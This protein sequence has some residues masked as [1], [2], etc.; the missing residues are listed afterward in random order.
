MLR[1][2]WKT[3]WSEYRRFIFSKSFVILIFSIIFIMEEIVA[4]IKSLSL[5]TGVPAGKTEAFLLIMSH[6][7]YAMLLPLVFIVILSNFPDSCS[8]RIYIMIRSDRVSWLLGELLYACLSGL[9]CML[10][11]LLTSIL[12]MGKA[13]Q[14]MNQWSDFMTVFFQ[15]FPEEYT[16]NSAFFIQASTVAQGTPL[17]VLLQGL[18]LMLGN[19]ICIALLLALF[20]MLGK[21]WVGLITAIMITIIGAAGCYYFGN[22]K[23]IFPMAHAIYG[24]HFVEFYA[25]PECYLWW[26]YLYYFI[27][28]MILL[29]SALILVKHIRI[30]DED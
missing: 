19:M 17:R 30:G 27:I 16:Y 15:M 2:I 23:W 14:F 8:S 7:E 9:T 26:S 21:K 25:K 12:W 3:A 28:S 29:V 6:P 20:K 18:C 22:L 4:K 13:G 1:R 5:Q 11:L 24:L 10:V